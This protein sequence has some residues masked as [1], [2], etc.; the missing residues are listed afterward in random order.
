V[1][2]PAGVGFSFADTDED[3]LTDDATSAADN[4]ELVLQFLKRFPERRSNPFYVASESYGGHY[5]PQLTLEILK[6]NTNDFI[7]FKGFLV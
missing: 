7:N 2:Q 6:K 1:E 3:L 4:Y 5:M